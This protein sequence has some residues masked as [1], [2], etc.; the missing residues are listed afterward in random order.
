MPKYQFVNVT[1]TNILT[2]ECEAVGTLGIQFS[3]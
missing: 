2:S 1:D 3:S